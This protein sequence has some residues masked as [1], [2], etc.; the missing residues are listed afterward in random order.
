MKLFAILKDSFREALDTKVLYLTVPLSLLFVLFV[1]SIS[2]KPLDVRSEANNLASEFN[3]NVDQAVSKG[4]LQL[5]AQ[6]PHFSVANFEETKPEAQPWERGYHFQLVVELPIEGTAEERETVG[7]AMAKDMPKAMMMSPGWMWARDVTAKYVPEGTEK[8][9]HIQVDIPRTGASDRGQWP[10][11]PRIGFG[12][13]PLHWLTI[14]LNAQL[15]VVTDWIVG[16]IGAG[17]TLLLSI[18]VTAFFIPNMLRKGTVDMLI[19][20]PMHRTTLLLYKFIGGLTFMVINT[21]VIIG[22][23]YL[24]LGVRTGVWMSGLLLCIGV[25]TF[26]FAIFY[27][28]STFAAVTT[29]SAV[30]AILLSILAWFGLFVI[31]WGY[32]IL[33]ADRPERVA[34]REG[35]VRHESMLPAWAY[36]TGDVIHFMT[37]HYKDLDV[38][39]TKLILTDFYASDAKELKSVNEMIGSINWTETISVTT[40]YIFVLVG[41]S[42]FLFAMKDY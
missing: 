2:F 4:N 29:R 13:V 37:P 14:P 6:R 39:A 34:K 42:C 38:L 5:G 26:Q 17:L 19:S 20:K 21:V 9:V 25:F 27:A 31:G 1:F 41:L 23:L 10:H 28:L 40:L 11:E 30:V 35:G 22:G 8:E 7:E 12:L 16:W 36:T 15:L 32:R 33:D 18:I 24:A 3:A